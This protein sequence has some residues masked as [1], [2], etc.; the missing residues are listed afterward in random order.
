MFYNENTLT[1]KTK[2]TL[3]YLDLFFLKLTLEGK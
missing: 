1:Q 2:V 3:H